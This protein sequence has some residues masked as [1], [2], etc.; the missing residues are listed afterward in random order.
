MQEKH[1]AEPAPGDMRYYDSILDAI[2][3]TPLVRL[4]KVAADV[5]PLVLAKIEMLN[6]GG[7]VKDRIG[8]AMIEYCERQGLLR[9]GG[10]IVEPTSGNTGHGLA[11]AAAIKG[12][13][14]I[15][16]M[17]DKVSEEKRSLLRAYGA[18][19]VICPS[20]VPPDSPE[21]YKNVAHRLAKEIPGA[22]CPDQYSNPANPAAHYASTGPEIWRDTAGRITAFVAG[23]G[24][25]GTITGTARYL[26]EQNPAIKVIG[27]DPAGSVYSGD[28]PK[29][30]K[31]EGIGMEVFPKNYDPSI[32]DEVIRVEDRISFYW[33]RRLAREEG[34]LVGGSSGTALAAAL[35]YARRL[36]PNDVVVVL[37]PDTGRGYLSKQ[38]N[39]T[40]MRENNLLM[41]AESEQ[42]TLRDVLTYRRTH[43]GSMPLVVSVA[44]Q[45]SIADAV[46]LLR[47]YGISQTPVMEDGRM[48]GSLTEDLLLLHLASGESL[49]E[50]TVGSLQGPPFP[51]LPADAP[52][53]EAYTLFR[54]GHSAVAVMQ[55]PQ[56]EGIVTRSDLLEF[57]AHSRERTC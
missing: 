4:R 28:T 50:K 40:W 41:Q 26:K 31:V 9:P 5:P 13:H 39:D 21:H 20:T 12:Y 16:V 6:P 23:I 51:E 19:V 47:R 10:T 44:P 8:P 18:E 35:T 29:P 46:Q 45:D 15:F 42:P 38:F 14:C 36:T 37:F 34:I 24:T 52:I 7:S 33:A 1:A 56:L 48:V 55:G 2:G 30:Y 25:G 3:N 11:I 43:E 27:A 53:Q 54:G 49:S 57:W 32:V 17:T 22:C